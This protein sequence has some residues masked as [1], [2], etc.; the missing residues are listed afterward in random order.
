MKIRVFFFLVFVSFGLIAQNKVDSVGRKQGKWIINNPYYDSV[1]H[2]NNSLRVCNYI[3]DTL[4]GDFCIY[5]QHNKLVYKGVYAQ[6]K[7][8]GAELFY[9]GRQKLLRI[10]DHINDSIIVIYD[11]LGRKKPYRMMTYKNGVL[12]GISI[13]YKRSGKIRSISYYAEGRLVGDIEFK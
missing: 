3:N 2:L 7:V 9:T 1:L 4:D 10:Q 5:N 13:Q 6:G 11:F 12:N 8:I